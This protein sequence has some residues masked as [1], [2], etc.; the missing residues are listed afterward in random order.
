MTNV[1]AFLHSSTVNYYRYILCT[2]QYPSIVQYNYINNLCVCASQSML[3]RL[4]T[5]EQ[6]CEH[7]R[8]M[9]SR[10]TISYNGAVLF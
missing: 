10:S 8:N 9:W 1:F 5:A 3:V 6:V 7:K 4:F 2:K